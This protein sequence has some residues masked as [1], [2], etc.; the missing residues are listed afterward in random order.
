MHIAS[1]RV[2]DIE[3]YCHQE[4]DELYGASEVKAMVRMLFEAFV[5]WDMAMLLSRREETVDQSDLLR[6]HWAVEDLKRWRPIQQIIGWTTF[7]GCRIAVDEHTLIP[8]PETEEIVEHILSTYGDQ[9]PRRVA[10]LCTGSGCITIALAKRWPEATV[11]AVDYSEEALTVAQRN[12]AENGVS[13]QFVRADLLS[14]GWEAALPP[15]PFDLLVSNPPYVRDSERTAMRRNVTEYEPAM[16]LFVPDETPLVF[17]ES[18]ARF[19]QRRLATD[20]MGI[21]EINESLGKETAAMFES[22]GF[23]AAIAEDFRGK[24]RAVTIHP[25]KGCYNQ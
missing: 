1:N 24:E 13:V 5:G 17:Y 10:D 25:K 16:A 20:G 11:I 14:E 9:A 2:R 21:V 12:A 22:A 23:N 19:A 6:F 7:C 18:I 3:R 8:R 4:L 15:H